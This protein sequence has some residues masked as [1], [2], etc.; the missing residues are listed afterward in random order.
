MGCDYLIEEDEVVIE[1]VDRKSGEVVDKLRIDRDEF[2]SEEM[3]LNI[4]G[5]KWR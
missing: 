1:V 3:N 2:E 4:R 5:A